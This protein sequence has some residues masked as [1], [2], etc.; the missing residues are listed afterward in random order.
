MIEDNAAIGKLHDALKAMKQDPSCKINPNAVAIKAG[1]SNALLYKT[2][3][4]MVL[5]K[6]DIDKEKISRERELDT[7][8]LRHKIEKLENKIISLQKLKVNVTAKDNSVEWMK[9]LLEVYTMNDNMK[10]KIQDFENDNKYSSI[11][12]T[13]Q[14]NRETGEVISGVFDK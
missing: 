10:V 8:K 7:Q 3:P 5:L 6:I 1:V 14:V 4:R 12:K 9:H 13:L 2:W 11:E